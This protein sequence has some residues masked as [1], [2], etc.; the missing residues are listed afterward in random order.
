MAL[1]SGMQKRPF[2]QNLAPR[3]LVELNLSKRTINKQLVL[4]KAFRVQGGA[5]FQRTPRT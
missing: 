5:V 2:S 1:H 4:T 3:Q